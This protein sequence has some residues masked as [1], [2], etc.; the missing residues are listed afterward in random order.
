MVKPSDTRKAVTTKKPTPNLSTNNEMFDFGP[1]DAY[2]K[3][4]ESDT[5]SGLIILENNLKQN[6]I[7]FLV[8]HLVKNIKLYLLI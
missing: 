4:T 1:L 6:Q 7:L 5:Y 2:Q 8:I 3:E